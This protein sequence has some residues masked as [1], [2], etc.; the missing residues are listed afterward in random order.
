[1]AR[2]NFHQLWDAAKL[3]D[4]ILL[5]ISPENYPLIK[6]PRKEVILVLPIVA[7]RAG[8]VKGLTSAACS[9]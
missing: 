4:F 7:P 2:S 5:S 3:D 1:M 8:Q 6:S 9:L